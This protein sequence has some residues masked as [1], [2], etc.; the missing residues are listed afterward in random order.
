MKK[1]LKGNI[2]AIVTPFSRDSSQIDYESH[3]HHIDWLIQQGVD[4]IVTVGTTGES[5]TLSFDEHKNLMSFV[6]EFVNKRVPVIAG[7]GGNNTEE[8]VYLTEIAKKIGAD[9]GLSV[10]PYYNKPPQEGLYRH[11]MKVFE[12]SEGLPIILY[13]VPGRTAINLLPETV[14][15]IC[16]RVGNCAGV[17][18]ASGNLRYVRE[19]VSR[20]INVFCG[21]DF[22][23]FP[24]LT[25]GA[26]GVISVVSNFNPR[27]VSSLIKA[28]KSGDMKTANLVNREVIQAEEMAFVESNPIPTKYICAKMDLIKYP[29]VRLPLV[30]HDQ[31]DPNIDVKIYDFVC[32]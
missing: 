20:G 30:S 26:N 27:S 6:C 7:I 15:R 13:N 1:K 12:V 29:S 3:A 19:Y 5:A 9:A 25:C 18:E 22:M 14:F 32:R 10:T 4:G 24:M 31:L 11:F 16:D 23:N 2:V 21:E 8:A 17:K 28:V